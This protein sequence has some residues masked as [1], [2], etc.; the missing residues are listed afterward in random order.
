MNPPGRVP[1][2]R[3]IVWVNCAVSLDG[4]LAFAGG[5][6]ARLSGAEDLARVQRMRADADAILVGAGTVVADDPSLRV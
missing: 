4:R 5:A 2:D 1:A 3:P 6:R